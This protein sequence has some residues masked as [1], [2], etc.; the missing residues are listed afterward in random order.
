[1]DKKQ[2]S[3]LAKAAKAIAVAQ[4]KLNTAVAILQE[5]QGG[6]DAAEIKRQP[7]AEKAVSAETARQ[8]RSGRR[9]QQEKAES[10]RRSRRLDE[11]ESGDKDRKRKAADVIPLKGKAVVES[12]AS[13]S[14]GGDKWAADEDLPRRASNRRTTVAAA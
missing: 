4:E 10:A 14:K 1:M 11:K 3:A 5:L 7:R 13:R 8:P 2:A 9:G 12:K 6:G